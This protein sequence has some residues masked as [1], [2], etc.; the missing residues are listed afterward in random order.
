MNLNQLQQMQKQIQE[1]AEA[2]HELKLEFQNVSRPANEIILDEV[3]MR[4]LLKI[5]PRTSIKWRQQRVITYTQIVNK[6]Y[7]KLS[8]IIE[9]M[10]KYAVKPISKQQKIRIKL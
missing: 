7:Y 6:F 3:D 5:S 2:I 9:T 1:L 8:D 10:D 4:N